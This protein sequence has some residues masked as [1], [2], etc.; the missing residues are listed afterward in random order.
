MPGPCPDIV[1]TFDN[2]QVLQRSWRINV[3][4][5]MKSSTVTMNVAFEIDANLNSRT[6]HDAT[7]KPAIWYENELS[8]NISM[9]FLET[10]DKDNEA[11]RICY[12]PLQDHITE[13]V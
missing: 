1:I 12:K 4:K 6:E 13:A 2:N 10:A 3:D 9:H 7:L 5:K 11:K 8:N